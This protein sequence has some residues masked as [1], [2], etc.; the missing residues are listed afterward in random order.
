MHDIEKFASK[1]D[2]HPGI[3]VGRL[4]KENI[5]SFDK[6]NGLKVPYEITKNE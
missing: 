6:M 3:V 2:I 1:I 4:Q 5:I